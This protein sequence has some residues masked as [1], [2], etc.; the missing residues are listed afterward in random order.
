MVRFFSV[1]ILIAPPPH[2]T[3]LSGLF[4]VE[5]EKALLKITRKQACRYPMYLPLTHFHFQKPRNNPLWRCQPQAKCRIVFNPWQSLDMVLKFLNYAV[6]Q[7]VHNSPKFTI[8]NTWFRA[9]Q[10]SSAGKRTFGEWNKHSR[11]PCWEI[12]KSLHKP[13]VP[14]RVKSY[15]FLNCWAAFPLHS[16]EDLGG[17]FWLY[18]GNTLSV[19]QRR[20]RRKR[21]WYRGGGA[22]ET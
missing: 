1:K 12:E 11:K 6:G 9:T 10:P 22:F 17:S 7:R 16:F 18:S 2:P 21:I 8:Q 13:M 5:P 19:I 20:L 4:W 3:D 15:Q 14:F